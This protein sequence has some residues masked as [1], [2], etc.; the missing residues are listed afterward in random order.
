MPIY[1]DTRGNT[2]L[3]VAVCDRCRCK[4]PYTELYPD[5][6]FPGMRVCKEDLDNFDPWRLPAR[7]TEN[8]A[9]RFPRPDTDIALTANQLLTES[10][11]QEGNSFFIDGVAPTSNGQGDLNTYSAPPSPQT[12]FPNIQNIAPVSG[13]TAG[14]LTVTIKGINFTEVNTVKFGTV[15]GTNLQIINSTELTVKTPAHAAGTV[16]VKII[17]PFGVAVAR[18][19]F[20]FY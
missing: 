11:F 13:S 10:G 8:I 9:L 5:P 17:S 6:N 20:L 15:N 14:G 19:G 3:S 7:Q 18:N 16:D 4:F 12:L 1:L 2:I